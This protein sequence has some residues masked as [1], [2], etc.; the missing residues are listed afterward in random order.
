[1]N[2]STTISTL[3]ETLASQSPHRLFKAGHGCSR[4]GQCYP[5]NKSLSVGGQ[6]SKFCYTHPLDSDLSF[7]QRYGLFE[8]L[9]CP[10]LQSMLDSDRSQRSSLE[11]LLGIVVQYS[12]EKKKHWSRACLTYLRTRTLSES[13]MWVGNRKEILKPTFERYPFVRASKS[14]EGVTLSL[15]ISLRGPVQIINVVVRT[16]LFC[17]NPHRNGFSFFKVTYL[18]YPFKV[19]CSQRRDTQCCPHR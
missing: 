18:L 19:H 3:P 6:R 10:S 11:F 8:Q 1:M 2:N 13:M 16:K 14:D 17:N 15:S 4:G 9:N 7:E 5:L 12:W